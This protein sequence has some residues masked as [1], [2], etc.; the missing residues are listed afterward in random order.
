MFGVILLLIAL[1]VILPGFILVAVLLRLSQ[2]IR[3]LERRIDPRPAVAPASVSSPAPVPRPVAAAAV[4]AR[5]PAGPAWNSEQVIGGTWLQ[6]IGS[7]LVLLGVF[8]LFLWGY[9]TGRFGP[10]VLVAA[11][12]AVGALLVWRGD[13]TIRSL[14]A[15]GHAVIGIGLGVAYLALYS[16]HFVLRVFG[17]APAI[18]LL[19]I[20]AVTSIAVG[21]RYRVQLIS[22]LGVIG[23]F[24]PWIAGFFTG[25]VPPVGNAGALLAYLVLVDAISFFLAAR[26]GWSGLALTATVLTTITWVV[27]QGPTAWSLP[28]QLGLCALYLGLGLALVPR[29]VAGRA[30]DRLVDQ[31]AIAAAPWAFAVASAPFLSDA[32]RMTAM[33][34][35]LGMAVVYA[36]AA[37][38]VDERRPR[39]D[40]WSQFV[41]AASAFVAAALERGLGETLTP[42]AWSVEGATLVALGLAPRAG[43]LRLAGYLI[44]G[45]GTVLALPAV[46]GFS[47][48]PVL[49]P[50]SIRTALSIAALLVTARLLERHR[51]VLL[52]GE[53]ESVPSLS[54]AAA[55]ACLAGWLM[56]HASRLAWAFIA[57]DTPGA[58]QLQGVVASAF[59]ALAWSIQGSALVLAGLRG[60]R[61]WTRAIGYGIVAFAGVAFFVGT[62]MLGWAAGAPQGGHPALRMAAAALALA[63]VPWVVLVERAVRER[64][65]LASGEIGV[66]KAV[67]LVAL[68]GGLA[69]SVSVSGLLTRGI[70]DAA[71]RFT[72]GAALASAAWTAQAIVVFT[73]GWFR[74]S[75]YLRWLGIATLG[76]T[77]LKFLLLDLARVDTFWRFLTAIAVGC[78]LLA[79]SYVYQRARRSAA[80]PAVVAPGA[81]NAYA[82]ADRT[83][84]D[85]S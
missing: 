20:A 60:R 63:F 58:A 48:L 22:I 21:M 79:L 4:P 62:S 77:I 29:I 85:H 40:L 49:T 65:G 72:I 73:L 61:G 41:I 81:G 18:A 70:E 82:P 44:L 75:P 69:W 30:T 37:W 19:A 7:V 67:T 68:V 11:G 76:L 9:R 26:A 23:A 59:A 45:F 17:I 16:G 12:V 33:A 2:R 66:L 53:R 5:V 31:A 15:F 42:L 1:F 78:V 6:N 83:R 57:A 43:A 10:G 71:G 50:G 84:K 64:P 74:G 27:T 8:F 36:A 80:A 13:R 25:A 55:H 51:D 24:I 54:L 3:D 46:G 39:R 38:L 35:L 32:P 52:E 47:S 56:V 34:I 28:V 14:P